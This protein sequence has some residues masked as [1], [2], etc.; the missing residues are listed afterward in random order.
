M[1]VCGPRVSRIAANA[2]PRRF[3]LGVTSIEIQPLQIYLPD[4]VVNSTI[5]SAINAAG[6]NPRGVVWIQ[7]SYG[8]TD[9]Y[10]NPKN[11]PIFDMRGGG[12]LSFAGGG[13][14]SSFA[15]SFNNQT[16]LVVTGVTHA[17]GTA[18]LIATV[19]DSAS[20]ARHVVIPDSISI[21]SNTFDVTVSFV[22]SQSGRIV[23]V[24]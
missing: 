7:A 13:T 1:F 8:G 3:L 6:T 15:T 9:T 24:A 21:D 5:Q 4:G 22:Q 10:T 17:L 12:S 18:D 20:G 14:V 23:I 11:V 16:T 19:Y 2:S